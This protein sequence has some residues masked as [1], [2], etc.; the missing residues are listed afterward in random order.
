MPLFLDSANINLTQGLT[1]LDPT[2]RTRL[3]VRLV[4][5]FRTR[6]TR[7]GDRDFRTD[8]LPVD[9]LARGIFCFFNK[10]QK[11]KK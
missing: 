8:F 2:R 1:F 6:R 7:L 11:I 4:E 5:A 3:G 10:K 9:R